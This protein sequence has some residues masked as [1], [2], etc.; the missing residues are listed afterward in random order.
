MGKRGVCRSDTVPVFF[1]SVLPVARGPER[2]SN[3][4]GFLAGQMLSDF[5]L[6]FKEAGWLVLVIFRV[7][8]CAGII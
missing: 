3:P 1:Q 2:R 7:S 8:K 4:D 6:C 5:A